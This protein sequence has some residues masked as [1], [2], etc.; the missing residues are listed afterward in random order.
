MSKMIVISHW[1]LYI[2]N[3]HTLAH[4][5]CSSSHWMIRARLLKIPFANYQRIIQA[6]HV[7]NLF[8]EHNIYRNYQFLN[9][10]APLG[11]N[12]AVVVAV[13]VCGKC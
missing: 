3:G 9:G 1:S 5:H 13:G 4:V 8:Y 7:V 11:L 6:K 12:V 2:D 10:D